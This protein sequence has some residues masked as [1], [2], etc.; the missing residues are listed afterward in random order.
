MLRTDAPTDV[1]IT[2]TPDEAAS[3]VQGG[4][5]YLIERSAEQCL[6]NWLQER[7]SARSIHRTCRFQVIWIPIA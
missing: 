1:Q 5:P 2:P 6:C 7:K 3:V 4:L